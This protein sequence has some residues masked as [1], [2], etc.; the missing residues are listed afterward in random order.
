MNG[1]AMSGVAAQRPAGARALGQRTVLATDLDG[2][3]VGGS[4]EQRES[5]YDWIREHREELVLMFVSGRGQAHM[6][7]LAEDIGLQPDYRI[8][9]VGTSVEARDPQAHEAIAPVT[10]WLNDTWPAYAPRRIE[11]FMQRHPRLRPQQITGGLRKS[12]LYDDEPAALRAAGELRTMG[13]DV[14]LSDGQYF[15]VLP[16]GVQKGPTLVRVL[17]A[18][19]L[20]SQRTLVAGDTLNDLSMFRTGLNGVAVANREPGLERALRGCSNVYL[21]PLPGAAGVLDA[22]RRFHQHQGAQAWLRNS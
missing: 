3:F 19:G 22:V 4:R 14:L 12:Y 10:R 20:S 21:S 5:L 13:F 2:T 17:R 16:R 11:E 6:R 7:E 15:D 8:G 18:L 9:D 1:A